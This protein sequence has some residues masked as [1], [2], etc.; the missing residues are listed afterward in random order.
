MQHVKTLAEKRMVGPARM[1]ESA[2]LAHNQNISNSSKDNRNITNVHS[3]D[4]RNGK[5][6]KNIKSI[7]IDASN[8]SI[9]SKKLKK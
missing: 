8:L 6:A 4:S 1:L 9:F 5:F 2:V 7:I 3:R